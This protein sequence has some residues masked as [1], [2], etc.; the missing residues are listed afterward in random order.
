MGDAE[1]QFQFSI[2]PPWEHGAVSQAPVLH[3]EAKRDWDL[4]I[5]G[6]CWLC[7]HAC[8]AKALSPWHSIITQLPGLH[9]QI[10]QARVCVLTG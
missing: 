10:E 1:L 7:C 8:A 3:E 9:M 2:M 6:C 5:H 4:G